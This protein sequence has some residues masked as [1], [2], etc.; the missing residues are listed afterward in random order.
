MKNNRST[1]LFGI[2]LILLGGIILFNNIGLT[3]VSIEEVFSTYWPLLLIIWA[4]DNLLRK[5]NIKTKGQ[6]IFSSLIL[7]IGII[8]LGR[9]MGFYHMNLS[10]F[11]KSIWPILII[12]FGVSLLKGASKTNSSG[13][14]FMS[15]IEQKHNK[16][17]L[18]NKSYLA[19]MGGIELDLTAADIPDEEIY[20]DLTA[21]MGS[22]EIKAPE[23][24]NVVCN[25]TVFMGGI[26]FFK[27]GVGGIIVNRS[28]EHR[29]QQ[30]NSTQKIIIGCRA[31]MGGIEIKGI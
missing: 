26:D 22:I 4:L 1:I 17:Q 9:N 18:E 11:W 5:E 3:D 19:F 20:L 10:L 24:L 7:I 12:L 8:I 25:S 13:I 16:W 31:I 30:D 2:I 23:H 15:G 6:T 27:E 29:G 21:I 28:F 14:A